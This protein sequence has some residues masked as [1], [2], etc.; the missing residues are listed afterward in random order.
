MMGFMQVSA[1]GLRLHEDCRTIQ[2]ASAPAELSR[3]V[4]AAAYL[5]P[6]LLTITIAYNSIH[7]GIAM[8]LG[9]ASFAFSAFG[10]LMFAYG[11]AFRRELVYFVAKWK[12]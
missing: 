5:V 1:V 6:I 4:R 3:S 2:V 8:A 11:Y 9:L 7:F 10:S 12:Q